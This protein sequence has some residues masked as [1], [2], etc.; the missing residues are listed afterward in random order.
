M[1]NRHKIDLGKFEITM[2]KIL[3]IE[4]DRQLRAMLKQMLERAQHQ[5]IEAESGFDGLEKFK[6]DNP[7]LLILDM[8]TPGKDGLEILEELKAEQ[9]N[10]KVIAISGGVKGDT[11]WLQPLALS[12]GVT[13]FLAKPFT[14]ADLLAAVQAALS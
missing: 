9:T 13:S 8:L 3:I 7:D 1:L 4:D 10:L 12:K 5:V 2:A 11:S 14:K 6:L